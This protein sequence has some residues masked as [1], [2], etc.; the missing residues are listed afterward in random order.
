MVNLQVITAQHGLEQSPAQRRHA[1]FVNSNV[2]TGRSRSRRGLPRCAL[3][4]R[5]VARCVF[6]AT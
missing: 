3:K 6:T 1:S 4:L 5:R 2:P